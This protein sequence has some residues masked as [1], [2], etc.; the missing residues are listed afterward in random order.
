[1]SLIIMRLAK[2]NIYQLEKKGG[3]TKLHRYSYSHPFCV[4]LN[5]TVAIDKKI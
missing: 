4:K 3:L 5:I 2:N 1:M